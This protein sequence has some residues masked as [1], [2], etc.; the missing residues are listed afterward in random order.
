MGIRPFLK[1][2]RRRL[3]NLTH[4]E[5]YLFADTR[6]IIGDIYTCNSVVG[7]ICETFDE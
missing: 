3:I 5:I 7:M 1:V 4:F 2:V 6:F